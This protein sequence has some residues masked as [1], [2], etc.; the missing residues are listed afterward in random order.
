MS[1]ITLPGRTLAMVDTHVNED[2]NAGQIAEITMLAAQEMLRL[3]IVPRAALLSHSN[4]GSSATAG[5]RKMRDALMQVRERMPELEIDGEMQGDCALDETL[6]RAYLPSSTLSGEAN[7]LVMP[8][9][10]SANIAYNLVKSA[11]GDNVG[12]GPILL[13]CNDAVHILTPTAS[14][15]RIVNMTALAVMDANAPR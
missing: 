3:G 4:F 6:R 5:A 8:D 2:P 14:I 7:L 10:D 15:R 9:L 12:I 13:G 11:S 1:L